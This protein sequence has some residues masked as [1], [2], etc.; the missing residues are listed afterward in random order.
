M[1]RGKTSGLRNKIANINWLRTSGVIVIIVG[2]FWLGWGIGSDKISTDSIFSRTLNKNLPSDLDYAT[3][4]KVYDEL[5][6][7]YDGTLDHQKL[8]EGLKSGLVEAAGDAYT[9]FLS[10]EEAKEFDEVLAGSFIGIGAELGKKPD[11]QQIIVVAPIS[12]FPAEKAGLKAQD[13]IIEIDGQSANS[14]SISEA[15]NRIRGDEGTVVKLKVARS[16]NK[17]LDFSIVR[18]KITI[19]SVSYKLMKGNIGYIKISMFNEDTATLVREAASYLKGQNIMGVILD[20]RDD[21]GGLLDG[22]IEVSSVWL[23]N[24]IVLYEKRGTEVIRTFRSDNLPILEGMPTVV[25]INQGS[26]SASEIVAGAL[27]DNGAATLIGQK[28]FGKGSVQQL[29]KLSDGSALKV[30]IARWYT[31]SDKN[32]N[33][34]GITPD[35]TVELTEEDAKNQIDP[36]LDAA[37]EFLTK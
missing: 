9:E 1:F 18:T 10:A 7:Q 22:A 24:K 37:I 32:I 26:A 21:P 19:P 17:E 27:R 35:K 12:G 8:I 13:V 29:I 4:E 36:Q 25:L 28:S 14:L 15:V 16:G 6:N 20:V 5:R 3:V 23:N 11:T 30:T 33:K 34:E 31:P 2:I